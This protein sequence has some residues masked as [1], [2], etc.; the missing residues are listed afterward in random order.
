VVAAVRDASERKRVEDEG[1]RLPKD[2]S[3]FW[4]NVVVTAV[5]DEAGALHGFA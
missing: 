2:G 3:R 1:W 4:A 5:Y